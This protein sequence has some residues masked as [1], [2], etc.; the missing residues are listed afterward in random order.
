MAQLVIEG[1][2]EEVL[3]QQE[4]LRGKRVRVTVLE[5]SATEVQTE[6][7]NLLEFLQPFV[8]CIDSDELPPARD[9][10]KEVEEIISEKHSRRSKPK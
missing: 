7:K 8:G 2:W 5:E 6:A 10:Q 3:A 1:V 9:I 4:K